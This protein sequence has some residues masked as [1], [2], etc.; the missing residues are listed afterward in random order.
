M[1]PNPIPGEPIV[2]G[3]LIGVQ[4]PQLLSILQRTRDLRAPSPWAVTPRGGQFNLGG[5]GRW[6]LCEAEV[7]G[8]AC[9]GICSGAPLLT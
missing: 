9:V 7:E 5:E 6:G 1:R 3:G 2:L 4:P 8:F